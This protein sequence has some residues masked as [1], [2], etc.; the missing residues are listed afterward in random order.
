MPKVETIIAKGHKN[1][2]G[3]HRTTFEITKEKEISRAADCIIGV[4]ANKG[5][6]DLSEEIKRELKKAKNIEIKIKLPEYNLE[7]TIIAKGD[8]KLKL[9]HT[10]DVVIRKSN[11]ICDRTL[12]IKANKAAKDINREIISLLS[13]P[14]TEVV[15]VI[16]PI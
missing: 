15:L 6:A 2:K 9:T 16:L 11:F 8:S 7:E 1:I 4:K 10:T 5:L 12:A 13:D 3:T 14:K